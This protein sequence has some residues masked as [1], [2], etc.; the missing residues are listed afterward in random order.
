[1]SWPRKVLLTEGER[2][3]LRAL[4]EALTAEDPALSRLLD[5]ATEPRRA[6][7]RMSWLLHVYVVLSVLLVLLGVGAADARLQGFAVLMLL[8]AP[9]CRPCIA[10]LKRRWS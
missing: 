7:R 4:E 3:A 5:S 9:V 6:R 1:M 2:R 8:S 10:A